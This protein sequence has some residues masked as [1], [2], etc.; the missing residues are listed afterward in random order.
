MSIGDIATTSLSHVK[1]K[2]PIGRQS[3]LLKVSCGWS[4]PCSFAHLANTTCQFISTAET[5]AQP[6]TAQC[7]TLSNSLTRL[8]RSVCLTWKHPL[9]G[10]KRTIQLVTRATLFLQRNAKIPAVATLREHTPPR[11]RTRRVSNKTCTQDNTND[12]F[13]ESAR[14]RTGQGFEGQQLHDDSTPLNYGSPQR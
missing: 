11:K 14:Q 5:G 1:A 4:R 2:L 8:F 6:H 9:A 10:N 7:Q 13:P 12:P 3:W